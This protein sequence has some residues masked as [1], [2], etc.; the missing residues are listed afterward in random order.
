MRSRRRALLALPLLVGA[1]C[2]AAGRS[3]LERGAER[4]A[5]AGAGARDL[6]AAGFH[7]WLHGNDP[8][9]ATARFGEALVDGAGDRLDELV[10][11]Q[12]DGAVGA[13]ARHVLHASIV[14]D[15]ATI[16]VEGDGAGR[17]GADV[18]RED[19]RL[20]AGAR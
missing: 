10:G 15:G 6:A 19:A 5:S 17:A 14:T 7:A 9:A 3:P 12:L 4:A 2:A 8:G 11:I 16:L 1:A 13:R 20:P 18:D